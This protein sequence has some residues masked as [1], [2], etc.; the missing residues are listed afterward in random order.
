MKRKMTSALA[1]WISIAIYTNAQAQTPEC[2]TNLSIFNEHA[3]V[4]NYEAAH[5][6]WKMVLENCP[7]LNSATYVRGEKIL[8]YKIKNTQ[9]EEKQNF[10]KELM[11]MHDKSFQYFPKKFPLGRINA[12]K[13]ILMYDQKVGTDEELLSLL[14]ETLQKDKENFKNA[15]ALYIY[16]SLLVD[17]HKAGKKE[18]QEIF[19][20]YDEAMEKIEEQEKAL[21]KVVDKLLLKEEDSTLTLTSK[22]KR[23]LKIKQT[24]LKAFNKVA[25]GIEAKLGAL[26]DCENL[27]PLYQNN[28]ENKKTDVTW[29]KRAA[30]KMYKK[31]CTDDPLFFK[32]VETY[33]GIE[34]SA[35][36][37]YY[38]AILASKKDINKALE[39]FEESINL[40]QDPYEKAKVALSA[41]SKL[42]DK[43]RKS[44]ARKYAQK[45]LQYQPSL[46]KAYLLIASL[47]GTSANQCGT[48]TLEKKA[49]YWLAARTARKASQVDASLKSRANKL[50]A[51]YEARVPTKTEIFNANM[52]GKTVTFKCWIGRSIKVPNL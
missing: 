27:V 36:S 26:A 11:T 18:L 30:G 38:L 33:H 48:T 15:K 39:Y 41:A 43:G 17:Q 47:Y 28:F 3:K 1:L 21:L 42:K 2:L 22:E 5:K 23:R 51:S 25:G 50:A 32:L 52:A 40:H 12:D 8:E 4:K 35:N 10:I 6:P 34:P 29:L 9:G 13:A 46:G 14:E 16:F 24:N 44:A 37:A 19:D 7:E 31:E 45:A 20:A 49:V